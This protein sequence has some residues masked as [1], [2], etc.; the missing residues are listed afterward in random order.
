MTWIILYQSVSDCLELA[1]KVGN[2]INVISEGPLSLTSLDSET[3]VQNLGLA[4]LNA[5]ED[6]VDNGTCGG[7]WDLELLTVLV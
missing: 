6:L 1:D 2:A 5:V 4:R 7:V 3:A